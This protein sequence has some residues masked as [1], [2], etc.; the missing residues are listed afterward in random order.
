MKH[1]ASTIPANTLAREDAERA[2]L[3]RLT[4]QNPLGWK[5][6]GRDAAGNARLRC[7]HKLASG[8]VRHVQLT[9]ADEGMLYITRVVHAG[10]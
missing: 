4:K 2:V 1:K 5:P 3:E 8:A 10:G 6:A 9:I 7:A